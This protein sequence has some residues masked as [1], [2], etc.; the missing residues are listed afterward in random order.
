M[1][2][3]KEDMPKSQLTRNG[4]AKPSQ[5]C[6]DRFVKTCLYVAKSG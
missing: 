4:R 5:D 3:A 1:S 2:F 6:N